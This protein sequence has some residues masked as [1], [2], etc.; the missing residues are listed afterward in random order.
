MNKFSIVMPLFN[1]ENYLDKTIESVL[2]QNYPNFELIIIDDG[3][4]DNSAR[5]VK[6][7]DD[8][9]IKYV[10]QNNLGVSVSRNRGV[11]YAKEKY[12]CFLDADDIWYEDFLDTINNL[13]MQYS[14]AGAYC[15]A[16]DYFYKGSKQTIEYPNL[17]KGD[18]DG[19]VENYF[20]TFSLGNSI[21]MSS[22]IC[23]PKTIFENVGY[24]KENVNH[25]EDTEM[26]SRIALSYP[27]VYTKKTCARYNV[28]DKVRI[29]KSMFYIV[30]SLQY[31]LD[32]D[33]VPKENL[34]EVKNVIEYQIL[35]S[36]LSM[37]LSGEKV[38]ASKTLDDSRLEHTKYTK[39]KYI[40]KTMTNLPTFVTINLMY[41]WKSFRTFM[42]WINT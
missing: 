27:V 10:Y 2:H 23:I 6:S 32:N 31:L 36:V 8:I 11:S 37:L 15:T 28:E 12:I 4:T 26:W 1:K 35:M 17:L 3:S 20:E 14:D 22:N 9:R 34:Q 19:Y 18:F 33:K 38:E 25:T 40:L 39:K 7:F 42:G 16:I 41:L 24:F 5:I 30:E 21:M 29:T 13:I